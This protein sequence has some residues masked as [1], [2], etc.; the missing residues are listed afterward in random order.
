MIL[1]LD[2]TEDIK[3]VKLVRAILSEPKLKMKDIVRERAHK[4]GPDTCFCGTKQIE[5]T[6]STPYMDCCGDRFL[7][8]WSGMRDNKYLVVDIPHQYLLVEQVLK[9]VLPES[10]RLQCG[11]TGPKRCYLHKWKNIISV[12]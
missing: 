3:N 9:V 12:T 6:F 7:P 11:F 10:R 8:F 1:L 2:T 5:G 4:D